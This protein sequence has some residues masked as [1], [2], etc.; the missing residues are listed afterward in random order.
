MFYMDLIEDNFDLILCNNHKPIAY[1]V[2]AMAIHF[3]PPVDK[4]EPHTRSPAR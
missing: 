2:T 3:F 4:S 1:S